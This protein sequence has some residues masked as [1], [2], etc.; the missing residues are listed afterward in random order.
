MKFERFSCGL[1]LKLASSDP[2]AKTGVLSGYGAIFGNKDSYGDV[3]KKGAF[4]DTLRDAKKRGAMPKMLLQHGGFIGP[5]ED[6]I[7]VGV[8]KSMEEDDVGLKVEGE[9]FALDT[10][11]GRYI[12]EGLKSGALDG[13]SI[14][15][16]AREVEYGKKPEDPPRTLKKIDLMEVS[17][18]TFPANGEARVADVK[19]IETLATLSDAEDYLRDACGF[20]RQQARTFVSRVKGM[21][22]RD[23]DKPPELE[24]VRTLAQLR[25]R[26]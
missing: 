16:I 14:G 2:D 22:Q 1:E 11:K 8:W 23:A 19:T 7:P 17:I 3:I 25:K 6:G 21:G 15:Y 26:L 5:A 10:Q 24:L 18:V 12:Y 9:L 20:S 4:R 13:L